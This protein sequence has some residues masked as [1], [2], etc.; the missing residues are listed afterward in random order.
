MVA[1]KNKPEQANVTPLQLVALGANVSSTGCSLEQT[2]AQAIVQI[3]NCGFVIRAVSRFFQTPCFP[4]G[5]GPDYGNAA[6]AVQ[7]RFSAKESL[8]HLHRIEADFGR[9]RKQRW[10]QRTLDL[11]LIA[12]GDLVLPNEAG[13]RVWHDMDPQMQAKAAPTELVLP[14]PRIQDRGFV[15]VPLADVAPNWRHPVL[16]KTVR[17]M[18]AELAPADVAEV[19][20]L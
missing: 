20:A 18:L 11:D 19:V 16:G 4:S 15:L 3:A 13:Y 5:A 12:M 9:E 7:S 2:L 17:E 1:V 14:H 8:T 6:L 10:G